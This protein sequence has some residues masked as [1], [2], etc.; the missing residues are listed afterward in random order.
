MYKFVTLSENWNHCSITNM[1]TTTLS[2]GD[3]EYMFLRKFGVCVCVYTE[4]RGKHIGDFLYNKE[5]LGRFTLIT[6]H[7][8]EVCIC[9]CWK[10]RYRKANE[11][12]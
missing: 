8:N 6:L 11:R 5:N 7:K 4:I 3:L 10:Q 1:L 12:M 9:V 2:Q